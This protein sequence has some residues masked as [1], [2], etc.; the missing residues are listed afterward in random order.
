ME[1]QGRVWLGWSILFSRPA[2]LKASSV[3]LFHS[4]TQ[5]TQRKFQK[6]RYPRPSSQYNQKL[7]GG[8]MEKFIQVLALL[9]TPAAHRPSPCVLVS[10]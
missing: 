8:D 7:F 5:Y 3:S 1:P 6:S 4:R 2:P 9:H 10:L